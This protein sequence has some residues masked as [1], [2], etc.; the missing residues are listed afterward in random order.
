MLGVLPWIL[1]SVLTVPYAPYCDSRP[2]ASGKSSVHHRTGSESA[3]DNRDELKLQRTFCCLFLLFIIVTESICTFC[4]CCCTQCV[5]LSVFFCVCGR[6]S[7]FDV[8]VTSCYLDVTKRR[9]E[10]AR[11][12]AWESETHFQR[13]LTDSIDGLRNKCIK[14]KCVFLQH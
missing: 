5:D 12:K 6:H 13:P 7:M 2:L 10:T 14:C 4:L 11:E 3:R 9:G 1:L 8:C